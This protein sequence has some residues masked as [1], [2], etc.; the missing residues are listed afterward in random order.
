MMKENFYLGMFSLSFVFLSLPHLRHFLLLSIFFFALWHT[1]PTCLHFRLHSVYT[2]HMSRRSSLCVRARPTLWTD[3]YFYILLDLVSMIVI[4]NIVYN[5]K[6]TCSASILHRWRSV[7]EELKCSFRLEQ[8]S[9]T[10][11]LFTQYEFMCY[12]LL[13]MSDVFVFM[14]SIEIDILTRNSA[15]RIPFKSRRYFHERKIKTDSSIVYFAK[16]W[17]YLSMSTH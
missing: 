4:V 7:S 8:T 14:F 17:R 15:M 1:M 11:H 2:V 5:N 13:P 6:V 9:P 12:W 10:R 16:C 3:M